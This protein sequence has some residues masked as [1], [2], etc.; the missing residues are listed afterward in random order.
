M[1]F[2]LSPRHA[3]PLAVSRRVWLLILL[4]M[5][6]ISPLTIA[7]AEPSEKIVTLTIDF[8]DGV[9]KRFTQLPWNDKLT[10]L[11]ALELAAKHHRGVK[12][13]QR[14][15]GETAFVDSIDGLKD[16]RQGKA[17]IYSINDRTGE[18]SAGIAA[19]APGDAILWKFDIYR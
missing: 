8:G 15:S 5:G 18:K 1:E 19:L 4:A 17:W 7:A 12:F 9:Q 2:W 13:T 6:L 14:G 10:V 3:Q 16:Q 11:G